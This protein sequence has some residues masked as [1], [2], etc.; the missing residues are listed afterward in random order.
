MKVTLMNSILKKIATSMITR[1]R[2]DT[3]DMASQVDIVI[4][5]D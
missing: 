4:R 5:D 2:N 1:L 3:L